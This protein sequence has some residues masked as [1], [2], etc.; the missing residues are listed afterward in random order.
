MFIAKLGR[1]YRVPI[2]PLS[3]HTLNPLLLTSLHHTGTFVT[4][5]EPALTYYHS[6]FIVYIIDVVV[7]EF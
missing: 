3:S 1:N 7:D 6:K 2:Y 4:I 5:N